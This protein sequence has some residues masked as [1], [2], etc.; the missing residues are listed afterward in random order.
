MSRQAIQAEAIAPLTNGGDSAA[1]TQP[2]LLEFAAQ[3]QNLSIDRPGPTTK[4]GPCHPQQLL[5]AAHK[6]GWHQQGAQQGKFSWAE[7]H[8][9]FPKRD[10]T[11]QQVNFQRANGDPL[12]QSGMATFQQRAAASRELFESEGFTQH[13]IGPVIEKANHWLC[14]RACRQNDDRAT[15]VLRQTER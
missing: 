12:L 1:F 14:P 15:Q 3:S 8:W 10:L 2:G 13:V 5:S 9:L 7:L 6:P 11:K 4:W